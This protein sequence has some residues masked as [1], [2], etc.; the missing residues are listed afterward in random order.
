MV[1]HRAGRYFE[2]RLVSLIILKIW[3]LCPR[4]I[5]LFVAQGDATSHHCILWCHFLC[6]STHECFINWELGLRWKRFFLK[7]WSLCARHPW[8]LGHEA[9]ARGSIHCH[10]PLTA[11]NKEASGDWW[12]LP[13]K[14]ERLWVGK[15]VGGCAS[16]TMTR[17]LQLRLHFLVYNQVFSPISFLPL[18]L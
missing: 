1:F 6:P 3:K 11:W 17:S 12:P 14:P 4:K 10:A 8:L 18:L 13:E 2:H 15:K 7:L 5:N 16:F 9:W